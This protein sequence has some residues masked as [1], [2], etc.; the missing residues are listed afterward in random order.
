MQAVKFQIKLISV[1]SLLKLVRASQDPCAPA[2]LYRAA[3]IH[4]CPVPA[5]HRDR[6][7][8]ASEYL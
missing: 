1:A 7:A 6:Y 3:Q 4:P 5:S 8:I 2:V